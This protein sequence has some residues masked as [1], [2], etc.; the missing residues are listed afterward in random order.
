M[1][2]RFKDHFLRKQEGQGDG[3]ELEHD[4]KG[5]LVALD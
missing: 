4:A 2:T 5:R 3:V 1:P